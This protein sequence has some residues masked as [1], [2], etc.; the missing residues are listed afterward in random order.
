MLLFHPQHILSPC[1]GPCLCAHFT[2]GETEAQLRG[3]LT[4]DGPGAAQ[5]A[6]HVLS[7]GTFRVAVAPFYRIHLERGQPSLGTFWE[8]GWDNK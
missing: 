6:L 5:S 4:M 7:Q 2:D 8:A 3:T 1:K